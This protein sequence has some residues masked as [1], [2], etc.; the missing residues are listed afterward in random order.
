MAFDTDEVHW[1]HGNELDRLACMRLRKKLV[2]ACSRHCASCYMASKQTDLVAFFAGP[3]QSTRGRR[4]RRNEVKDLQRPLTKQ[5]AVEGDRGEGYIVRDQELDTTPATE[6]NRSRPRSV[7][8]PISAKKQTKLYHISTEVAQRIMTKYPDTWEWTKDAQKVR[9]LQCK[10]CKYVL[11]SKF[12]AAKGKVSRHMQSG[13]HCSCVKQW[14]EQ[15]RKKNEIYGALGVSLHHKTL[16]DNT[17]NFRASC[18]AAF[19]SAGIPLNKIEALRPFLEHYC[20]AK[21]DDV[22]NLKKVYLPM[23]QSVICNEIKDAIASGCKVCAIHDGTN[24]FS[25]FYSVVLR[26]CTTDF[27]IEERLVAL[28]AFVGAQ[29]ATQLAFMVEQVLSECGVHKGGFRE[30]G[31]QENGSLLAIIRDRAM[32][33]TKAAKVLSFM[34]IG[35]IDLECLSHT[36]NTVGEKMPL[37]C[38]T[39]F[40]DNLIIALNSQAFK[41]HCKNFVDKEIRKPS[42]TRWWS[43]WELFAMLLSEV[44]SQD[45]SISSVFSMLLAAFRGAVDARGAIAIEGVFEDSVRVRTLVE[46]AMNEERVEDVMLELAV[47]VGVMRPFVQATYALEGAGCCVLEVGVWFH[48]L[49]S[50]WS[51]HEPTLSFPK[52]RDT[53][54]VV[55]AARTRRGIYDQ[56]AN[57]RTVLETR[58]RGLIQPVTDQLRFVFNLQDGE[59]HPDVQFYL[60]C[61]TLNPYAH[62]RPEH[63]MTPNDFKAAVLKYFGGWFSQADV[64]GMIGDLPQF[65]LEC[66]RF[67][68]ENAQQDPNDDHRKTSKHR[69]VAIWKFWKRLH[70]ESRC[71]QLRRLA[72]LVLSIAPS[73]AAAERSFS[74]LKAYFDSQQLIGEHRGALQD[75]IE[76]MIAQAFATNNKKN[77]FHGDGD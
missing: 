26:W 7:P 16:S 32:V 29:K 41:E 5:R 48:T 51:T 44:Q 77:D 52:V 35:Y 20:G 8:K 31:S 67:V 58:V 55:A 12:S 76:T 1:P 14:Q 11:D 56:H 61:A 42:A 17:N 13:S 70:R 25:E 19:M 63:A 66:V 38:L 59:L 4:K 22:S 3:A 43:T 49:A 64:D 47:A 75:Y 50:F 23:L 65:A 71:P 34:Y 2:A 36:F 21:L 40:R 10:Y 74:L 69:N 72:Q 6:D 54:E 62:G 60:F 57:A 24:R 37:P 39:T 15:E 33:N 27:N 53:I 28:K 68:A 46:F 18:V 73:S 30:D 45:G 9:Y